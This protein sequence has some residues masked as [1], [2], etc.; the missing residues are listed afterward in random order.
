MNKKM[1]CVFFDV[2]S[3]SATNS[4][5]FSDIL[6]NERVER[7]HSNFYLRICAAS[8]KR[9]CFSASL[10]FS[11]F[12]FCLFSVLFLITSLKRIGSPRFAECV[13]FFP[14]SSTTQLHHPCSP[15]LRL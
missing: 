4:L 15:L 13:V 8:H 14:D 9:F 7:L 12:F 3:L 1:E 6:N 10:F 11:F 2:V 5:S